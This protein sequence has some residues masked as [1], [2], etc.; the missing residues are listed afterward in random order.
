MKT[1]EGR[2]FGLALVWVLA[3]S[4]SGCQSGTGA[5]RTVRDSDEVVTEAPRRGESRSQKEESETLESGESPDQELVEREQ[6]AAPGLL[7]GYEFERVLPEPIHTFALGNAPRISA[8]GESAWIFD[9]KKWREA[10]VP[11][12]LKTWSGS[13]AGVRIFYGRD[14]Q[15]RIMGWYLEGEASVGVYLRHKVTGWQR[16][17]GEQGRLGNSRGALYGVLGEADPEVLCRPSDV[18]LIKRVS[19]WS[20]TP[21]DDAPAW[22]QMSGGQVLKASAQGVSRLVGDTWQQLAGDLPGLPVTSLSASSSEVMGA[23]AG[24]KAFRLVD[25]KWL[26]IST[27]HEQVRTLNFSAEGELWVGGS[28]GLCRQEGDAWSCAAEELGDVVQIEHD[29]QVLFVASSRGL[30]R[31]VHP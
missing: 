1:S 27:P 4:A 16:D 19:G 25:G 9:G 11:S 29:G 30:Y 21:A 5:A 13:P 24:G 18:C 12:H 14:N 20:Q 8:L 22:V 26:A 6:G 10:K 17:P 23:A 31:A 7:D 2:G 15:P 28:A 3:L